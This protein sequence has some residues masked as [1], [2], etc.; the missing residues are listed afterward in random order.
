MR[1]SDS[2]DDDP[3]SPFRPFAIAIV[4]L[5][6]AL[7]VA[8]AAKI[9]GL[10]L[11]SSAQRAFDRLCARPP[12]SPMALGAM[13]VL[14]VVVLWT[15]SSIAVQHLVFES[16]H[17]R[18]PYFVTYFSMATLMIYLPF[19]PRRTKRLIDALRGKQ[20]P[21]ELVREGGATSRPGDSSTRSAPVGPLGELAIGARVGCLFF[22]SQVREIASDCFRL[23]PIAPDCS[24]L[25]LIASRPLLRVAA[26]LR[27][28][29]RT[30][31]RLLGH[32]DRGLLVA[33]DAPPLEPSITL[34]WA[35]H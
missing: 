15:A 28:R 26:L 18:K 5:L 19:Y 2:G 33:V 30:L 22:A 8:A 9:W 6:I 14:L 21:Y 4:G 11:L 24:R 13:L 7:L 29:P 16:A 20:N 31:D 27:H 3:S 34:Q 10:Q 35:F 12:C 17:Y 32:A 25:L 1:A 23:L